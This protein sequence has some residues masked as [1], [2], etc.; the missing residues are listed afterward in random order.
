MTQKKSQT[1]SI[2]WIER[3]P[4]DG[5][6][7]GKGLI[8]T[9]ATLEMEA[10]HLEK[11]AAEATEK[12]IARRRLARQTAK[13]AQKEAPSLFSQAQIERAVSMQADAEAASAATPS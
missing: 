1:D 13:R 2:A 8:E 11:V 4:D 12:A 5:G 9:V 7:W 6:V 3:L 10:D